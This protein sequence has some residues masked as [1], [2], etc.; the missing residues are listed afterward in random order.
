VFAQKGYTGATGKEICRR[1]HANPAAVVYHFGGME[2]LYR[3]CLQEAR[4]RLAPSEALAAAVARHTDAK[5]RLTA[6]IGLMGRRLSGPTSSSW[7]ARLISREMVSPSAIFDEIR[8]KEMRARKEILEAIVADLAGLNKDHPAVA[9]TCINIMA[10]L[11]VIL[12]MG[13]PRI[14]KAFPTLSFSPEQVE[15]TTHYM[16]EYA[17]GGIAAA[18]R[19]R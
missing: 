1:S 18:A 6:F 10:P 15:A 7:A 17:L 11:A 5:A 12:L 4:S 16:V 9:R 3:A 14:E 19:E 2:N 13:A 8:S